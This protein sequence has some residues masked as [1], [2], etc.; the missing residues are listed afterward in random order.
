MRAAW[1]PCFAQGYSCAATG[2]ILAS[3]RRAA[4]GHRELPL[5]GTPG[6]GVEIM[7]VATIGRAVRRWQERNRAR[8]ELQRLSDRDL[9]DIGLTRSGIEAALRGDL[10]GT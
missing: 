4:G 1:Q 10:S 3:D 7:H 6:K 5:R 9:A 2:R 8:R